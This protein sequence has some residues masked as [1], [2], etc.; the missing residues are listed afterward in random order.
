[1]DELFGDNVITLEIPTDEILEGL[2]KQ[3]A[4]QIK[5]IMQT[6]TS[7]DDSTDELVNYIKYGFE[8]CKYKDIFNY[9]CFAMALNLLLWDT[10]K[11]DPELATIYE[12]AWFLFD[13]S[14]AK[15]YQGEDLEY[16]FKLT[17]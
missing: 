15:F 12:E 9:T 16:Y 1:M 14:V 7:K 11:K 4:D 13:S 2:P 3:E 6:L 10:Y 5:Y 8:A 17:R